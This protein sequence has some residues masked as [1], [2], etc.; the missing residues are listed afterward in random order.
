[1][2]QLGLPTV[3]LLQAIRRIV[4]EDRLRNDSNI[5][6]RQKRRIPRAGTEGG[7]FAKLIQLDMSEPAYE[8]VS[9]ATITTFLPAGTGTELERDDATGEVS[10]TATDVPVVNAAPRPYKG[11]DSSRSRVVLAVPLATGEYVPI[12]TATDPFLDCVWCEWRMKVGASSISTGAEPDP[13]DSAAFD[14]LGGNAGTSPTTSEYWPHYA[15]LENNKVYLPYP[16]YYWLVMIAA[17]YMIDIGSPFVKTR[18]TSTSGGHTHTVDVEYNQLIVTQMRPTFGT[19]VNTEA[20]YWAY[21]VSPIG[22]ITSGS[23]WTLDVPTL[24][25]SGAIYVED[26]ETIEEK[27]F[28]PQFSPDFYQYDGGSPTCKVNF[29]AMII[30]LTRDWRREE[31]DGKAEWEHNPYA[32]GS[33]K[34]W[35]TGTEPS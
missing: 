3:E 33:F 12:P 25:W 6:S 22:A 18:T 9:G 4:R 14:L 16:G 11:A 27:Y 5:T 24:T 29:Y 1:M 35:G 19:G 20:A 30:P 8:E 28:Y 32:D 31:T 21:A 7:G 23:Q 34:W 13:T 15:R 26:D 2:A 10:L 17:P